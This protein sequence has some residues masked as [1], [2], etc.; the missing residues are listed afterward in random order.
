MSASSL[1]LKTNAATEWVL[2][3]MSHTQWAGVPTAIEAALFQQLPL[4]HACMHVKDS[5]DKMT[6][7]QRWAKVAKT[8]ENYT[9]MEF[10]QFLAE[11]CQYDHLPVWLNKDI[12]GRNT[13]G[14]SVLAAAGDR[15]PLK[16]QLTPCTEHPNSLPT[17]LCLDHVCVCRPISMCETTAVIYHDWPREREKK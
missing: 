1:K 16:H 7:A 4:F 8:Y 10:L 15:T 9:A 5:G 2:E 17:M 14:A 3:R 12:M 6:E 13:M 11:D